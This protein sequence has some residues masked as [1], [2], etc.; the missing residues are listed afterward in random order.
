[1]AIYSIKDL[2]KLS[3]IKAH[4]IRIWEQRYGLLQPK[5]TDT[6]IRYYM[7]DDLRLL[8][9]VALLKKNG[10][11]ISKIASMDDA[12]ISSKVKE[13]AEA[14]FEKETQLDTLTIAMIEMD[15]YKFDKIIS[16]NIDE[17]GFEQ[18]MLTVIHP[19]LEKLSLLWLTGSV[20]PIQESFTSYLIRQK[21]I[22]AIDKL[23]MVIGNAKKFMIYIPEGEMQELSVLFMQYLLK[24]R[25]FR[26]V[27]LGQNVGVSDLDIAIGIQC[28]DYIFTIISKS[29]KK[30]SIQEYIDH[31]S[32]SFPSINWLFSGMQFAPLSIKNKKNYTILTGLNDT[33]DFI[34]KI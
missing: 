23:P 34:S 20:R 4:T 22:V 30:Q 15:E 24:S 11:R 26:V 2:E 16:A 3:G 21:V 32:E 10:M 17:I 13:L 18:T 6:N 29:F 33:L 5:R 28:P 1:L 31:L 12:T 7:D 19:F 8:L 25:G 9:N 14:N 27:Y